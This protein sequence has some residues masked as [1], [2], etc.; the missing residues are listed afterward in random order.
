MAGVLPMN[1][2]MHYQYATTAN[3][4]NNMQNALAFLCNFNLCCNSDRITLATYT[5]M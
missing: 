4:E 2:I 5:E 3:T 1:D